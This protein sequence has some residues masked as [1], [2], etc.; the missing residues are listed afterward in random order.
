MT[1]SRGEPRPLF[2]LNLLAALTTARPVPDPALP[3]PGVAWPVAAEFHFLPNGPA[4]FVE[5]GFIPKGDV[6]EPLSREMWDELCERFGLP[7]LGLSGK[8]ERTT[9]D[10]RIEFGP[11]TAI[12]EGLSFGLFIQTPTTDWIAAVEETGSCFVVLGIGMGYLGGDR[13]GVPEGSV[14]F[15]ARFGGVYPGPRI[16]EIPGLHVLPFSTDAYDPLAHNTLILDADVVIGIERFCLAPNRRQDRTE[17]VRALMLNLAY[18][19]IWPGLALAQIYQRGRLA[20]AK[21]LV[22]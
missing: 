19:D 11:F 12:R 21:Q 13:L 18:R 17:V 2:P 6:A 20:S 9:H 4:V 3:R 8:P 16:N 15:D 5:Y 10:Y 7:R 22:F 1:P 14:A